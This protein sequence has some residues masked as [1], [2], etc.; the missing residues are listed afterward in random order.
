MDMTAS[1]WL[2]IWHFNNIKSLGISFLG[3]PVGEYFFLLF[4]PQELIGI[5]LVMRHLLKYGKI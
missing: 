4:V 3:L 5:F 1:V 2:R